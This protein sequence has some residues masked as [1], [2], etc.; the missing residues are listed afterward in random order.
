M[1]TTQHSHTHRPSHNGGLAQDVQGLRDGVAQLRSDA[2]ELV[3]TAVHAGKSGTA[4]VQSAAGDA[5]E[6]VKSVVTGGVSN[7][8]ERSQRSLKA[9]TTQIETHPVASTM[10]ALGAGYLL[11]KVFGRRK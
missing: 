6:R 11:A 3:Q 2:S 5:V 1:K 10:F 7:L 9:V 8:K 4:A